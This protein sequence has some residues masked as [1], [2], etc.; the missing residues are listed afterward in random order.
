VRTIALTDGKTTIE[1][2]AREFRRVADDYA[3]HLGL[4]AWSVQS[5]VMDG[6]AALAL[7]NCAAD[8]GFADLAK[9]LCRAFATMRGTITVGNTPRPPEADDEADVMELLG[10][11]KVL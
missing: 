8:M 4:H 2:P 9:Q 6:Y 7:S 1:V 5:G 11:M 10:E 3:K